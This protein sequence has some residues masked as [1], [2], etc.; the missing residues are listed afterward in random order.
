M[1]TKALRS[2]PPPAALALWLAAVIAGCPGGGEPTD[3]ALP[4]PRIT[5]ATAP[6]PALP[7]TLIRITGVDLDRLGTDP[8]LDGFR[9]GSAVFTLS[10]VP[11]DEPDALLFRLSGQAVDALGEGEHDLELVAVGR[12]LATPRYPIELSVARDLPLALDEGLAGDAHRNDV[13]VLD[14]D[15]FVTADEGDLVLHV[16]GTLARTAGGTVAVDARLPVSLVDRADR[17]RGVVV[18]STDLGGIATGTLTGTARLERI[19]AGGT[20]TS[21][22]TQPVALRFLP[23]ELFSF[24]GATASVGRLVT[25]RGA[26]F[27]GGADR[28][29]ETTLLRIDGT[30]T[31]AGGAAMPLRG[32]LVPRFVSGSEV[33]VVIET[34]VRD[35]AVIARFFGAQ[36]GVFVGTA[37]PITI[38]GRDELAGATVP[39][40]LVLGPPVQVVQLRFLP[41]Y[42]DSLARFGLASAEDEIAAGIVRR[43][44][45]I[46][47]GVNVDVR[48]EAPDDFDATATT[49]IEIGGPDPNGNGLFGYDNSPGKDVGN[50]RM[51]DAIGGANAETQADGFPGFGGV[52]VQSMLWWSSHPELPGGRPPSSPDPEPLFDEIFDP[53]RAR[54]ASRDEIDGAASPERLA[55]IRR[56][57]AALSSIIGETTAHE[58]GHSLGMAQPYGPVTAFHRDEDGDGCLMDRGGDRPL[59]ERAAQPGFARTIFCDDEPAYLREILGP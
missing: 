22:P 55:E 41:G 45:E 5:S 48:L 49:V 26:G 29:T 59:G 16:E 30:F 31:P 8:T 38:S 53:V 42:Y 2:G 3:A 19:L 40:S 56:A 39:L 46:Y 13:V 1:S 58:L 10:K 12:G 47:E 17:S 9:D 52:F 18:L 27:L 34:E 35:G 11:S 23:P 14:G 20:M 15:G 43:M 7:G 51:F 4:P 57:I 33:R 37:T 6:E 50:V 25:V 32:E 28:P 54:P 36:R 24:D 21:T 44:E